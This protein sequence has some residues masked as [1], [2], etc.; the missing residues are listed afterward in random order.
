MDRLDGN[1]L[2]GA[3]TELFA[4]DA[5]TAHGQCGMCDDIAALGQALVYGEP[6]GFVVRCRSCNSILL[7]L[8]EVAGRRT[9]NM[10]GLRWLQV[11][12]QAGPPVGDE[13]TLRGAPQ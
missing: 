5:T 13:R 10:R 9:L 7:V 12:D 6:M 1:V 11:P 2:A 4:F 3:T 8:R